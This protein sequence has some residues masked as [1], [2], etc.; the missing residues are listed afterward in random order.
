MTIVAITFLKSEISEAE[1]N[2]DSK[3]NGLLEGSSQ[4][5]SDQLCQG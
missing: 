3:S 1:G 5:P 4:T 2:K